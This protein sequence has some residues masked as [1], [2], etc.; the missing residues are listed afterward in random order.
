MSSEFASCI[1]TDLPFDK[2]YW[3]EM[4]I[5][6]NRWCEPELSDLLEDDEIQLWSADGSM[7]RGTHTATEDD[8]KTF[9]RLVADI[10]AKRIYASPIANLH[11]LSD[12]ELD[13]VLIAR[14][15]N[16]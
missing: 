7:Y 5:D 1:Y 15:L 11:E 16:N 13:C 12:N 2:I 14:G 4:L 8:V 6:S 10:V 9:R 3:P